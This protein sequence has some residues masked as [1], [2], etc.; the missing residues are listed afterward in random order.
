MSSCILLGG[1]P[2][3]I[4]L[5]DTSSWIRLGHTPSRICLG[6]TPSC[7]RLGDTPSHLSNPP[8]VYSL[9]SDSWNID[10][11]VVNDFR[12]CRFKAM[13]RNMENKTPFER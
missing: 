13:E 7:F 2:S 9:V 8:I 6:D 1:T 11:K 10:H 4:R 5:G 12:G 3:F